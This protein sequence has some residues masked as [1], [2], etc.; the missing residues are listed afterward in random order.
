MT[1]RQVYNIQWVKWGNH[2]DSIESLGTR[3]NRRV[4]QSVFPPNPDRHYGK[5]LIK[6]KK[7]QFF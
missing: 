4:N 5:Y 6:V 7:K 1:L 3:L 2:Q